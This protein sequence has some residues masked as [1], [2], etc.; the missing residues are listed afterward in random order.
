MGLFLLAPFYRLGA[1]PHFLNLLQVLRWRWGGPP[2]PPGPGPPGQ[3]RLGLVPAAAYLLHPSLG[4][5][6]WET[7]HPEVMAITPLFFA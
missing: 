2:L 6:A 5:F 7:F 4:F 1:G 3:A